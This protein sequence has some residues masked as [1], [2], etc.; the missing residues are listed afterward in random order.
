MGLFP[1]FI[2]CIILATF[3]AS[4]FIIIVFFCKKLKKSHLRKHFEEAYHVTLPHDSKLYKVKQPWPA[5]AFALRYPHWASARANG[6]ADRRCRNNRIVWDPCILCIGTYQVDIDNPLVMLRVV[7]DLRQNG[8]SI[9]LCKEEKEKLKLKHTKEKTLNAV[10][11][12]EIILEAFEN[13]PTQFEQFCAIIFESLGYTATVTPCVKDNGYDIVLKKDGKTGIVECKCYA[14]TNKVGRPAIQKVVGA[15]QTV[16]GDFGYSSN[17]VDALRKEGADDCIQRVQIPFVSNQRAGGKN[18]Q[19]AG[20]L[21]VCVQPHAG[22]QNQS[23]Q[24]AR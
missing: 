21:P 19:N 14:L 3:I 8:A 22:T 12:V 11:G 10:K 18:Q 4:P 9:S 24:A 1:R 13:T 15:N 2:V 23:I 5:N 16:G 17:R 6:L 20:L 7:R